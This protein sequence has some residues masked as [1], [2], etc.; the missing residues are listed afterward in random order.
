MA[1]LQGL[2][3]QTMTSLY[4]AITRLPL[5]ASLGQFK[6]AIHG[7]TNGK[8][9]LIGRAEMVSRSMRIS[10]SYSCNDPCP[11]YIVGWIN[12]LDDFILVGDSQN[13]SAWQTAYY[14]SG[15]NMGPYSSPAGWSLDSSA[16]S[17]DPTSA[18]T[19]TVTGEDAEVGGDVVITADMGW[20]ERYSWDGQNCYDNNFADPIVDSTSVQIAGVSYATMVEGP[21]YEDGTADFYTVS[22]CEVTCKESGSVRLNR[23]CGNTLSYKTRRQY[24]VKPSFILPRACVPGTV[25]YTGFC[26]SGAGCQ[27]LSLAP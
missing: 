9:L 13:T 16:A 17:M 5:N 23:T 6:W 15:Y 19:T 10:T 14:D 2:R 25:T 27:D 3:K 18:H 12:A 20:Q 4:P 21:E 24:W 26:T 1:V 22:P 8:L 7:V 11:P